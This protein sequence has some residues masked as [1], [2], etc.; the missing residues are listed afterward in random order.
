MRNHKIPVLALISYS[1]LTIIFTYP[2]AFSLASQAPGG[3]DLF[4]FIWFLW[5]FKV[6]LI[7]H[8]NPFF[9]PMIFY[10]SGVNLA[11]SAV[12]PFNSLLSVPLQIAFG[13]VSAYN[14][15]W[16]FTFIMSGFGG[17]LLVRYLT[18]DNRAAFISGLI[19]MFC[20]YHFAHALYGHLNLISMEWIP[21]YVLFLIKTLREKD[22]KNAFF[23]GI[24]L[25]LTA[26]CDYYYL[27]YLATFTA[28]FFVFCLWCDPATLLSRNTLKRIGVMVITF[29]VPFSFLISPLLLELF[30]SGS[31]YMY[32]GGFVQY[33][34]DLLG[35]FIPAPFH[36]VLGNFIAPIQHFT[37][38][39][40]ENTTF[41]GYTVLFLGLI[42]V[43]KRE[44][45]EILFWIT[46]TGVFFI[47]SLGPYL[48]FNGVMVMVPELNCPVYLPYFLIMNMP[49]VSLARA[50][51]R[52]DVLIMLSLMVLAGYGLHYLFSKYDG[53]SFGKVFKN[54]VIGV[55]FAVL[56]LFE[57][58]AIPFP[59]SDTTVPAFYKQ[60]ANDTDNYAILDI[61]GSVGNAQL[62]YYQTV[63]NKMLL[64]GYVSRTPE[65]ATRFMTA[66]PM[67]S[68]LLSDSPTLKPEDDILERNLTDLT[69][70]GSSILSYYHIRYVVL[71][72]VPA[73]QRTPGER[74]YKNIL[75]RESFTRGPQI[76]R[77]DTMIVYTVETVPRKSFVLFNEGWNGVEYWNGTPTRRM[78][79][80]ATMLF[81]SDQDRNTTL[82]MR[83]LSF[84][85]PGTLDVSVTD[86]RV[87]HTT[88]PAG[89][90]TVTLPVDLHKGEN[91]IRFTTPDTCRKPGDIPG[92]T[93]VDNRCLS[94]AVQNITFS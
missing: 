31:S 48:H 76:F 29:G 37:G 93:G 64:D 67:I 47:L 18:G 57:F 21:F 44:T 60:I 66:T 89:F 72:T 24:F 49:V 59:M 87:L 33:S 90:V 54:H 71:H 58:L 15:I 38:N 78:N 53:R 52:W 50:P 70:V 19:F 84:S 12:T 73:G 55:I 94:M 1:I 25:F 69:D 16:I 17:F 41:A 82:S 56:I 27:L 91:F 62:M 26:A 13:L 35:F 80:N 36:P 6:A 51:G 74:Y 28:L 65:S 7:S 61:P 8:L 4:Q 83:I 22:S 75:L 43:L 14:L 77:N 45:K 20:P 11:F 5:W 10:P 39:T 32:N 79:D 2:V 92:S 9:S 46:A 42:A 86:H 23:A 68:Q 30:F 88:V 85:R 81:Y 63:H 34:A 40:G 3:E